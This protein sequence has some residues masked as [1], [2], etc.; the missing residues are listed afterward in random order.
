MANPAD[1]DT[2]PQHHP[3]ARKGEEIKKDEGTEEGRH[4]SEKTG[5]DRPSG[6][7]TGRDSTRVNPQDPIDPTSPKMPPA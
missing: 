1:D 7:R 4:D 6:G 2:A 3:G 5:A